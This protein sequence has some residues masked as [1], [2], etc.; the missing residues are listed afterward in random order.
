VVPDLRREK[1]KHRADRWTKP[2]NNLSILIAI[3]Q[4]H[5]NINFALVELFH[6]SGHALR[7]DLSS[8]PCPER[9]IEREFP[10]S[11]SPRHPSISPPPPNLVLSLGL[12]RF[13]PTQAHLPPSPSPA[14]VLCAP[15][16]SAQPQ[17]ARQPLESQ[18]LQPLLVFGVFNKSAA[19]LPVLVWGLG[20]PA[21][22]RGQWQ[23]P[24]SEWTQWR[25]TAG[26][27]L[28]VEAWHCLLGR[29]CRSGDAVR[30]GIRSRPPRWG[31]VRGF[32]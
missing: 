11:V 16:R 28:P 22:D 18:T 13:D 23:S 4:R 1:G 29:R 2:V 24:G 10:L 30:D 32:W 20:R 26:A 21:H 8:I 15:G 5:I 17:Q 19:S 9:V 12:P 27:Q 31:G 3:S 25:P 7:V 6:T 14:R